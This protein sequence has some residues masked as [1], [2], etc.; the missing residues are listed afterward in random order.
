MYMYSVEYT[1]ETFLD[2]CSWW[3]IFYLCLLKYHYLFYM[4][5]LFSY[6]FIVHCCIL[7]YRLDNWLLL[8]KFFYFF[9]ILSNYIIIY[10]LYLFI[11]LFICQSLRVAY[12]SYIICFIY[13]LLIDLLDYDSNNYFFDLLCTYS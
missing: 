3:L 4:F 2:F 8:S 10:Y 5:L 7:V 1:F 9:L 11:Y 12:Y 6:L 13:Q